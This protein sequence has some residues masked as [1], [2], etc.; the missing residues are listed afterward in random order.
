[1][2][3]RTFEKLL[4]DAVIAEAEANGSMLNREYEPIPADAQARFEAALYGRTRAKETAKPVRSSTA[5][6]AQRAWQRKSLGRI[7]S[8]GLSAAAVI[9]ILVVVFG[10]GLFRGGAKGMKDDSPL[11]EIAESTFA[12]KPGEQ[13]PDAK[14]TAEPEPG[15]QPPD[16]QP[17]AEPAGEPP[18]PQEYE[19]LP[20][21]RVT[22]ADESEALLAMKAFYEAHGGLLDE[23][24]EDLR[25]PEHGYIANGVVYPVDGSNVFWDK[26]YASVTDPIRAFLALPD[27]GDYIVGWNLV[28]DGVE[29]EQEEY[30]VP[31]FS[32]ELRW[33]SDAGYYST[34]L[35]FAQDAD[36]LTNRYLYD[37]GGSVLEPV[38]ED[39]A[40]GV[41]TVCW[42]TAP[43]IHDTSFAPW[44]TTGVW[45][46]D[47]GLR[48]NILSSTDGLLIGRRGE[49]PCTRTARRG[50]SE[51]LTKRCAARSCALRGT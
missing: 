4:R 46:T 12:P 17:T 7:L 22:F 30:N 15:E 37:R 27:S 11:A 39:G 18:A 41:Y 14:P 42:K 31:I 35:V 48:L 38:T 19:P 24:M 13:A 26:P 6:T 16:A 51:H 32:V 9:A 43:V 40:W 49:T 20:Y 2:R 45:E 25:T 47:D 28:S 10:I 44:D 21:T 50:S 36:F 29:W 8:Y 3:K 33:T 34:E 23:L 5:R 1:M